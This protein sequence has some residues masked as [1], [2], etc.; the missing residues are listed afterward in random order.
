MSDAM[1]PVK[2][3]ME[4][5]FGIDVA[6]KYRVSSFPQFLVFTADGKL[7]KRLYGY[8]PPEQFIEELNAIVDGSAL[9]SYPGISSTFPLDVPDFLK[10]AFLKGKDRSNPEATTV[11]AWLDQQKGPHQRSRLDGHEPLCT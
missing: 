10:G 3:E 6:M 5:G 8:R 11:V 4:T 2:I 7:V 9:E 1:V